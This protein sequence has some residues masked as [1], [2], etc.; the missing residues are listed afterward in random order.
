M[1]ILYVVNNA[2][3]FCSHR[4][5]IALA[6]RAARHEVALATGGAG[7]PT[8]EEEALRELRSR[9]IPH[10]VVAFTSGGTNPVRELRGLWQLYLHVRRLRPALVHCA[11]PK[12]LLYGG[13]VARLAGVPG[14]VVA[15]SGMG[16]M[17]TAG[18]SW[19]LRMLHAAYGWV[20][21][22]AYGHPN[23][24]VIV[25]NLDDRR[26]VVERGLAREAHTV[27]IAGSGV[28]L[29]PYLA[30][31]L[32]DRQP[33]VVLPARLLKDKGVV[34]FI[35]AVRLLRARGVDWRFALVGTADYANPTAVSEAEVRAWER[36]GLIEWWGHRDDMPAVLGQ[37]RIVCLPSYREGMPKA[38]LEAAAAGCA[39]V[40]TDVTGCREAVVAGVTGDLV[41]PRDPSAL[42]DALQRLIDDPARCLAYGAAGRELARARFDIDAVVNRTLALYRELVPQDPT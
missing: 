34:E 37:A 40:T 23:K 18:A 42:A 4:L 14:L 41:P 11:S 22:F 1:K 9:S 39:V 19:P 6:A 12:G 16:S 31:G 26:A 38:L 36:A 25:Q 32:D 29:P 3:F 30:Q 27:L 7:S 15:V 8:L 33:L 17:A 35:E 21:R 10:H 20:V 2:S 28:K 5:P 13:L 24:R